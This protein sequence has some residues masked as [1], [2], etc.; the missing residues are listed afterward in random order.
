MRLS[1]IFPKRLAEWLP[2]CAWTATPNE[3]PCRRWRSPLFRLFPTR[4]DLV[5]IAC[6]EKMQGYLRGNRKVLGRLR[7]LGWI[8]RL[9]GVGL[10]DEGS[11]PRVT[12]R[13]EP[14]AHHPFDPNRCG[15]EPRTV[16]ALRVH[17]LRDRELKTQGAGR[18]PEASGKRCRGCRFS[19]LRQR[20]VLRGQRATTAAVTKRRSWRSCSTLVWS[21]RR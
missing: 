8:L 7:L 20:R 18:K 5:A 6:A 12:R 3:L 17:N 9:H 10:P 21:L 13:S 16:Q 11:N 15:I 19:Q 4:D 1:L 14:Q 2:S